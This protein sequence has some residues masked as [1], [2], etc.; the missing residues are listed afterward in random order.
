M[1]DLGRGMRREKEEVLRRRCD[2][3][4][5]SLSEKMQRVV[6]LGGEKGSSNWLSVIPLKEMSFDMNKREFRDAIRLLYDW[7]IPD[8]QS[9]CVC[10]V[11]FTVD[12]AMICKRGGF[13]IQRHNELRDL[14]LELS[15][16]VCYDIEVE[17]GLQ[18]VT[19][20]ELNRGANQSHD[21][22]LD[23]H[24]RG[25]W[26]R[27]RSAYFY[28]RVCH[29]HADCYKD[30]TLKQLNK[31]QEN[32]KKRKYASKILEV[33]QGT[34]TPPVFS[35]TEGMGEV[36]ARYHARFAELLAIKKGETY[37]TTVSWI[38]AKVLFAL[39][40]G[41]LLCL[42]GSRGNRKL[43]TNIHETNF[44]IERGLPDF[45]NRYIVYNPAY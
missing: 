24:A 37:S 10:G 27:E 11:R 7:P 3:L 33:E 4:K 31:Q 20:E 21:A 2:N 40:R 25:F 1:N 38:R 19:G 39:L 30:L 8:T 45:L 34:F 5:R 23:V 9:V 41:A 44:E 15:K 28:I 36:C 43:A 32:E 35:T 13:I 26:E 6:E 17:P 22:R 42:R 14:D 12:H 29:P 16:M 18:P